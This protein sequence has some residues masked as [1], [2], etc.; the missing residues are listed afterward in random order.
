[1]ATPSL[2]VPFLYHPSFTFSWSIPTSFCC[3]LIY[4]PAGAPEPVFLTAG[5]CLPTLPPSM[6]GHFC[7]NKSWYCSFAPQF[8][9][10]QGIVR[11]DPHHALWPRSKSTPPCLSCLLLSREPRLLL[12][13]VWTAHCFLPHALTHGGV[14]ASG[15]ALLLSL[16]WNSLCRLIPNAPPSSEMQMPP[17]VNSC[18]ATSLFKSRPTSQYSYLSLLLYSPADPDLL[19]HT[20]LNM[21]SHTNVC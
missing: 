9:G 21:K 11:G 19:R 10:L 18:S 8:P 5:H 17:P 20:V 12:Q 13:S 2:Q 7:L 1:M 15:Y 3:P 14:P 16:S 6:F 4:S